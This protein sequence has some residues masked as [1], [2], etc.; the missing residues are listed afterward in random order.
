MIK[1]FRMAIS[2][3]TF[4]RNFLTFGFIHSKLQNFLSVKKV[5]KL[6]FIKTN[7]IAFNETLVKCDNKFLSLIT[8][9]D[10]NNI[11]KAE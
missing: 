1:L 4:K 5:Q 8:K 7:Y 11:N 2:N 3:A 6:I 10:K 9:D